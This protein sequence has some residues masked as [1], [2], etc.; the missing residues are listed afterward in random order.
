MKVRIHKA[1]E[2]ENQFSELKVERRVTVT[3]KQNDTEKIKELKNSL[4]SM[5]AELNVE[6]Q[7][8]DGLFTEVIMKSLEVEA[9]LAL[10]DETAEISS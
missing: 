1:K 3:I 10:V 5:L 2:E 8:R 6:T 9:R 7:A 4:R